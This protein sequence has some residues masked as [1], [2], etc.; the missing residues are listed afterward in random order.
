MNK[1]ITI[2]IA[3]LAVAALALL[4]SSFMEKQT[5]E[6]PIIPPMIEEPE[7]LPLSNEGYVYD[8]KLNFGFNY[9]DGW[10][11]SVVV[12][13]DFEQCDPALSYETYNC[14]DDL[15]L[16]LRCINNITEQNI[17]IISEL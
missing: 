6:A 8:E 2:G 10:G 16:W 13:K 7:S 4:A 5:A 1:K 17:S 12:D 11:F 9:P 3:V 15:V 14:V